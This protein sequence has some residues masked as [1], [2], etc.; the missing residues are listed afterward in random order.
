MAKIF[1]K[2]DY[3]EMNRK[4]S[5]IPNSKI[6]G[7]VFLSLRL[8]LTLVTFIS[9]LFITEIGYIYAPLGAIL[10]YYLITYICLLKPLKLRVEK[11]D[12]EA[13]DFFE[14]LTLSL[15]SGKNLEQ[16]L[17]V[18]TNVVK[19]ELSEEFRK[20]LYEIKFGK[21]L[22]EAL[23][24]LKNKMPSITIDNIIL[25]LSQTNTYGA[26]IID[27]MNNQIDFLREKKILE[28]KEKINKLPNQISVISVLFI[29]PLILTIILG[30]F[31]INFFMK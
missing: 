16:A 10:V 14:V 7:E 1:R 27:C 15:E 2:K 22:D 19:S 5:M 23:N 17:E 13:L 21:S 28:T 20:A 26:D 9:L 31:V 25:D 24:S 11:L 30:P 6:N 18:T 8:T 29:V 4:F 3:L 12:F